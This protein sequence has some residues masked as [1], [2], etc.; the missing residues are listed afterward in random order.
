MLYLPSPGLFINPHFIPVGKP[1][2]V[3]KYSTSHFLI[4]GKPNNTQP[5]H[6]TDVSTL[7]EKKKIT[8]QPAPP[9]PRNPDLLIS[10]MIQSC[11]FSMISFVLYQSP[12][13]EQKHTKMENILTIVLLQDF[14]YLSLV[15]WKVVS[16]N[17][18]LKV[19]LV[20]DFSRNRVYFRAYIL[21]V[22]P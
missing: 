8:N 14:F 2:R 3:E 11:P 10:L 5:L 1:E 15:V 6:Y 20:L 16:A 7:P 13:D 19:K 12:W 21:K 18:G 4:V 17:L 9:R 22:L